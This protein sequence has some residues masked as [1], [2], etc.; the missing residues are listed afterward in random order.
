MVVSRSTS[1]MRECS[2]KNSGRAEQVQAFSQQASPV[3][4]QSTTAVLPSSAAS[5]R[6]TS[7]A[8]GAQLSR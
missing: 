8:S 1:L 2:F 5:T 6:P 4:T 7:S 3:P